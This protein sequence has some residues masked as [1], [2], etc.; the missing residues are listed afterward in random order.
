MVGLKAEEK[1]KP[2]VSIAV[3]VAVLAFAGTGT[4]AFAVTPGQSKISK[5][6]PVGDVA[7]LAP[8]SLASGESYISDSTTTFGSKSQS[9]IYQ[10]NLKGKWGVKFDVNQPEARPSGMNDIDAGAYYKLS[11]SLRVGGTLGFGEKTDPLQPS[12]LTQGKTDKTQPR[13]RLETSFKF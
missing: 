13:V 12:Q 1:M 4:L 9:K 5:A 7:A 11:P 2:L 6:N 8:L 3:C 10:F